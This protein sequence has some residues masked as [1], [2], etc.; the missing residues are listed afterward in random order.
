MSKALGT[1]EPPPSLRAPPVNCCCMLNSE[2]ARPRRRLEA[3]QSGVPRS[4]WNTVKYPEQE[5]EEGPRGGPGSWRVECCTE[6]QGQPV[7]AG[8]SAWVG[9]RRGA[10]LQSS[11]I[12]SMWLQPHPCV[13]SPCHETQHVLTQHPLHAR[14]WPSA[15]RERSKLK[16]C[17]SASETS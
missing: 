3:S 12:S 9:G 8:A 4:H 13:C 5:R 15:E 7:T 16:N 10:T 11:R 2:L 14:L 6:S 17:S 1:C